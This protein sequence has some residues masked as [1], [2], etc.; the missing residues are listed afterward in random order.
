MQEAYRQSKVTI[1]EM[2]FKDIFSISQTGESEADSKSAQ[3]QADGYGHALGQLLDEHRRQN[4][5][6]MQP[7][8]TD[9]VR[10]VQETI[11]TTIPAA[12]TN[13]YIQCMRAFRRIAIDYSIAGF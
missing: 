10:K 5:V 11:Y 12:C 2:M 13:N 9:L 7:P 1:L 3:E 4:G 8:I 6:E